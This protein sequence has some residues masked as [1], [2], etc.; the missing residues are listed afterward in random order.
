MGNL[1]LP[2]TTMTDYDAATFLT[3]GKHMID[4]LAVIMSVLMISAVVPGATEEC[5]S[6]R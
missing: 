2:G 6:R 5:H 3:D 1:A 4:N